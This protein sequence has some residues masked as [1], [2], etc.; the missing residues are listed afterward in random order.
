MKKSTFGKVG[1]D[2]LL[3]GIVLAFL[4]A[5]ITGL[6][7]AIQIGTIEFTW[8][9]FQPIVYTSIAAVLGYIIKNFLTNSEDKFL[10][11]ES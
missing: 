5:L 9:F 8:A 3:K 10:K 1:I 6:Y 2:D 4:T 11:S 7:N